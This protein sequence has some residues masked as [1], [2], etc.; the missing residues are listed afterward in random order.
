MVKYSEKLIQWTHFA[1]DV[2]ILMMTEVQ[3]KHMVIMRDEPD[4]KNAPGQT[5]TQ[6]LATMK[7]MGKFFLGKCG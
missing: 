2:A 6:K 7:K 1:G 4:M 3:A 5:F